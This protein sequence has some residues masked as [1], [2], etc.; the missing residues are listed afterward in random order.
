VRVKRDA[1]YA[2]GHSFDTGVYRTESGKEQ[3]V[4]K[5]NIGN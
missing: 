4:E 3:R 1:G 5:I 2:R